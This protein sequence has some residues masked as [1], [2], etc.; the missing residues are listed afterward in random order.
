MDLKG[1]YL[2]ERIFLSLMWVFTLAAAILT[3][4][5]DN[6]FVMF[7]TFVSGLATSALVSPGSN[8]PPFSPTKSSRRLLLSSP[9]FVQTNSQ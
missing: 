4:V 6:V 3:F 1:Q 7:V 9:Q 5:L 2:C 8:N